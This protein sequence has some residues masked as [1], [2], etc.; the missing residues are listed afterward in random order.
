[1]LFLDVKVAI[2][3]SPL[4]CRLLQK[5]LDH[6]DMWYQSQLESFRSLSK[7]YLPKS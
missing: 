5:E 7:Q 1:L 4:V 2:E 3:V 6:D